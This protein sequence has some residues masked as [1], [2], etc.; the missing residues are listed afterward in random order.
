VTP[1]AALLAVSGSTVALVAGCALAAA[2][3]SSSSAP[4]PFPGAAGDD[5][6]PGDMR[7]FEGPAVPTKYGPVQVAIAVR[8]T[9]LV[10]VWVLRLTDRYGRSVRASTSAVPILE[11]RSL[12]AGS[13]DID[14]VTGATW[15][16]EG[17]RRSLQAALDRA[18]PGQGAG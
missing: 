5:S 10:K 15:T 13:A 2:G 3:A 4:M 8:G 11:R 18:A 9:R 12:A 14:V 16:S 7:T 6:G 1:T 17:Y